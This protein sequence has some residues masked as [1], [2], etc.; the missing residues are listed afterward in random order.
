MQ[1]NYSPPLERDLIDTYERGE[2]LIL[3]AQ[4]VR[5]SLCNR[6][7]TLLPERAR[8]TTG[9]TAPSQPSSQPDLGTGE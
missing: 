8:P 3:R 6:M 2:E 7:R 5:M 4:A 9:H 1:S